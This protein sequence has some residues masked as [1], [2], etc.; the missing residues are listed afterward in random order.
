MSDVIAYA[1]L[2]LQGLLITLLVAGLGRPSQHWWLRWPAAVFVEIFRGTS[3]LVQMFWF[4]FAMPFFGIQL[5][6]LTAAVLALGLNEGAYA[7]EIVRGTI[8]SRARGQTEA[9]VALGIGPALR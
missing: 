4:F 6:P 1:P 3:L 8:G 7:A 2:L 9:C 5:A